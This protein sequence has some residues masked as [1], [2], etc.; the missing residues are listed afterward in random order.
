VVIRD[1]A[2]PWTDVGILLAI[3]MLLWTAAGVIFARRSICTV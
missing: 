1:Q 3:A 2:F